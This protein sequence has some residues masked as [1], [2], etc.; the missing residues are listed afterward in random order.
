MQASAANARFLQPGQSMNVWLALVTPESHGTSN[1][2]VF[3]VAA[4]L[5]TADGRVAASASRPCLVKYRSPVVRYIRYAHSTHS[6]LPLPVRNMW[7][8]SCS[9]RTC[10][11]HGRAYYSR[12]WEATWAVCID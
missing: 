10:L 2:D 1:A 8:A 7:E 4:E 3:Q 9:R 6:C 12:W 11:Q 5:V